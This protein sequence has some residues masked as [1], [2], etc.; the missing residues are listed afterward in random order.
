[1]V[2]G[3]FCKTY[4][5]EPLFYR[6]Q[7]GSSHHLE[8][9]NGLAALATKVSVFVTINLY[10]GGHEIEGMMITQKAQRFLDK[11]RDFSEDNNHTPCHLV[12]FRAI[13]IVVVVFVG[14]CLCP[15]FIL[16]GGK[17]YKENPL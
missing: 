8:R 2:A 7:I 5:L 6:L 14:G 4:F 11:F 15:P 1:M 9:T 12:L 3:P 13:D 16:R 10:R 17:G